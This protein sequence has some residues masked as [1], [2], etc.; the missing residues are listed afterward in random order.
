MKEYM[1]RCSLGAILTGRSKL[2]FNVAQERKSLLL[3]N[4]HATSATWGLFDSERGKKGDRRDS[5]FVESYG[6]K[7]RNSSTYKSS[8]VVFLCL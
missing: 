2:N 6:Y 7:E 5:D 3:G 4:K 1:E 8:N